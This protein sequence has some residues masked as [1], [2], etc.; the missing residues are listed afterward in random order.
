MA[1]FGIQKSASTTS[2][3]GKAAVEGKLLHVKSLLEE[4][5]QE[6]PPMTCLG[7]IVMARWFEFLCMSVIILNIFMIAYA[8]DYAASHPDDPSNKAIEI[9]ELFFVIFYS[10]ELLL[11]LVGL[12]KRFFFG[13][14]HRWNIFDLIVVVHSIYDTVDFYLLQKK[15]GGTGIK[16]LRLLRILKI[17]EMLRVIRVMRF[18]RE[19][20]LMVSSILGSVMSMFWAFVLIMMVTYMFGICFVQAVTAHRSLGLASEAEESKLLEYWGSL[21]TA[22]LSLYLSSTGGDSW[23]FV[24]EPLW[25]VGPHY[26]VLFLFY[27]AFFAFVITN[28]FTSLFV[29]ATMDI[30]ERDYARDIA[31]VI[32]QK[33]EYV[34]QLKKLFTFIDHDDSG[35]ISYAEFLD[36]LEDKNM[37][38]FASKLEIEPMDLT[39]LFALLSHDG[40]RKVD[41][42]AFVVGCM[43]IRGPAKSLDLIS[44][45][46]GHRK[47]QKH[48]AN[49]EKSCMEQLRAM[50]HEL[51]LFL[52]PS[53]KS[54]SEVVRGQ[55]DE[56]ALRRKYVQL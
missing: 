23:R 19:L 45:M 33:S 36:M 12:R 25:Q 54:A 48:L 50:D 53:I 39:T 5:Y 3:M 6:E 40:Q 9:A 38:A 14:D 37:Q 20:R 41:L 22:M 52:K 8:T 43:K 46:N 28:T 35:E 55:Q 2:S 10:I 13:Q 56:S 7:V 18:F 30:S 26:Y 47:S 27:I 1:K 29:E 4:G 44:L 31:R 17:L 51:Q 16:F 24:A 42:E 49:F 32:Q 11:K 15:D 21:G 34:L